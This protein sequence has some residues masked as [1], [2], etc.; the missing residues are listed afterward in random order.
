[1]SEL[2]DLLW[3]AEPPASAINIVH[4]YVGMLR[5]LL[6]PGLPPR[7]ACRWLVRHASGYRVA[8][9]AGTLD[10]LRFR[11]LVGQGREAVAHGHEARAVPLFAVALALCQGPARTGWRPAGASRVHRRGP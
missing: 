6:E 2:V 8:A 9:D 4:R 10:L 11:D 1:M 5:L 7:A 3:R